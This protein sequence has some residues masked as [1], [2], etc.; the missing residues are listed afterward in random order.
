MML[1][2]SAKH[3]HE[4]YRKIRKKITILKNLD[5][6]KSLS[7][8]KTVK[9]RESNIVKDINH[10]ISRKVVNYAKKHN[11]GIKLEDLTGIRNNKKQAKSFKVH[12]NSWAY[13]QL[14]QFIGYKA[15]LAG[16]C[17]AYV[18]PAYTSKTCH[19]CGLIGNRN[20]KAFECP[21]CGH[22]AHSDVNAAWNIAYKEQLLVEPRPGHSLYLGSLFQGNNVYNQRLVQE[23]DC[24]KG[25]AD[26][27]Q[28]ATVMNA[29]NL[30]TPVGRFASNDA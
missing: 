28:Q 6:V 30:R 18:E 29:T 10:K 11:C 5:R 2:K 20:S 21:H 1:G 23:G 25:N 12:L 15:Q 4:K 16:V 9:K 8:L 27:P 19:K 14:Q 22:T 7:K 24:A 3:V 17:V 13:Y 26:I